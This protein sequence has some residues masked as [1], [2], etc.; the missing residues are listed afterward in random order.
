MP[1]DGTLDEVEE[2]RSM[3][4]EQAD[5]IVDVAEIVRDGDGQYRV[6][7]MSSNGEVVWTTEKY[8]SREWAEK[9]AADTGRPVRVR[10]D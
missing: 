9:V 10:E 6:R 2:V 5:R 8:G 7:G 4:D 3:V 1:D